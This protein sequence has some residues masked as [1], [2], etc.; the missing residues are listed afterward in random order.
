LKRI[1]NKNRKLDAKPTPLMPFWD[2]IVELLYDKNLDSFCGEVIK[3]LYS[4]DKSMRYVVLKD[5]KGIFTYHLEEI[6]QFDE[7][8]W[9][10]ICDNDDAIP[11]MWETHL[12]SCGYSRFANEEDLMRDLKSQPE[13]KQYFV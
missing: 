8:E 2:N 5:E 3:V 4:K 11:A 6:Y 7:D 10:Y 12:G 9:K 1:F 13:Y